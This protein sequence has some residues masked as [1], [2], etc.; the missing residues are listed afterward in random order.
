[1]QEKQTI[2]ETIR[3][4][5]EPF[6]MRSVQGMSHF[7]RST[8]LSMP[9]FS[10]L[11]RLYHEGACEVHD[12]GRHFDVSSAAVSQ[13]VDRLVQGGLLVR[14][15]SPDDRRVRR[16][17]LDARGRALI[18]RGIEERYR[19]VNDLVGELPADERALV[20]K[21][22]P[23][24]I[25]AEK[26]LSQSEKALEPHGAESASRGANVAGRDA[27]SASRGAIKPPRERP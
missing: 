25:N 12:I 2:A 11:M 13:L 7:A 6:I 18:D 10:L 27:E 5:M 20:L 1:M 9:Q 4:W 17:A 19:W 8:G 15:E 24:L 23:A 16:I 22:L 21:A 14:Q 3:Q 26:R